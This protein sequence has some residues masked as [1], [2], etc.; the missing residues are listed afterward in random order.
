MPY[1]YRNEDESID[2]I[3]KMISDLRIPTGGDEKTPVKAVP[4]ELPES[5]LQ[6]LRLEVSVFPLRLKKTAPQSSLPV[7]CSLKL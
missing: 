6:R 3:A 1:V 2:A 7:I 4:G 5:E